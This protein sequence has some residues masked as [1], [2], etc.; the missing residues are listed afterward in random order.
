M[1]ETPSFS[2][3]AGGG[4]NAVRT[5]GVEGDEAVTQRPSVHGLVQNDVLWKDDHSDVLKFA[6]PFQDLSH[7]LGL[8][9]LHHATDPHD[10][11]PLRG[12]YEAERNIRS[13]LFKAHQCDKCPQ[14]PKLIHSTAKTRLHFQSCFGSNGDAPKHKE[15]VSF[16]SLSDAES[17]TIDCIWELD[18]VR[19]Q[20]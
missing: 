2:W 4:Q 9:L 11:L 13:L 8:G 5:L 18:R 12:L 17:R 10:N 19:H 16:K 7:W 20:L 6:E 15:L 14:G 3:G 1:Q